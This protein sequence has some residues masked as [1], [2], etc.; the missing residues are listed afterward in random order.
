[1]PAHGS[2]NNA[3]DASILVAVFLYKANDCTT[4]CEVT[5]LQ[6]PYTNE[7]HDPVG[8]PNDANVTEVI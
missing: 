1:V 3:V 4:L 8:L 2:P 6:P 5:E 7:P